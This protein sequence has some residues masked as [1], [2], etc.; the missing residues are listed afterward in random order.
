[1]HTLRR[2]LSALAITALLSTLLTLV[3]AS[4]TTTSATAGPGYQ[5]PKVGQCRDITNAQTIRRTNST[6]PIDCTEAHTVQT[7]YV[8][9][10][11]KRL[12]NG[13]RRALREAIETRCTP[14]AK[15]ALG[16]TP[17]KRLQSAY[18]YDLWIPTKAQKRQGARWFRC[19]L[20]LFGGKR[21]LAP[22]T[23]TSAPFLG[24][25]IPDSQRLCLDPEYYYTVCDRPHVFRAVAAVKLKNR[26]WPGK[27]RV[28]NAIAR[29]CVGAT[30]GV[31]TYFFAPSRS[32]WN[33]GLRW[34]RCYQKT[35]SR[36]TARKGTVS[37]FGLLVGP[38]NTQ[39]LARP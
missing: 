25:P 10:L 6:A 9:T 3:V 33:A 15:K 21:K 18:F 11:R 30:P 24:K 22:L 5:K 23:A 32:D 4:T 38:E 1:M 7:F 37:G 35:T 19:D 26:P 2:L 13:P 29:K 34:F 28:I 27:A 17:R 20:G 8:G 36:L 16:G 12:F 14:A 31:K 39:M